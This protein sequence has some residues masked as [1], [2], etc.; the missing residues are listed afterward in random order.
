MARLSPELEAASRIERELKK[1][2]IGG[3]VEVE[4]PS[5]K[6]C[7][8]LANYFSGRTEAAE[9]ANRGGVLYFRARRDA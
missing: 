1:V 2:P 8:Y 7:N 5:T 3:F 9:S 4:V 6:V